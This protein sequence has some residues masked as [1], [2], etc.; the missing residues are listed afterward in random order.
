[1][2]KKIILFLLLF[3][4]IVSAQSVLKNGSAYKV[5]MSEQ[6]LALI[7]QMLSE[8][9]SKKEIPGAVALVARKGQIVF[10][11]SYGEAS[12]GKAMD[13][14][15]I[16]RIASQT[17]A[18]TSTAVIMLWEEG[19]FRLDDPISKYIP[20]FAKMEVLD[21]FD[22]MDSS[23]TTKPA[24]TEITIRHLLTHTSG[25]GYGMIDNDDFKKIFQKAGITDA[26][27]TKPIILKEN[28]K[29]LA[30]MPLHFNPGEQYHYSESIDVL[31][32]FVEV[33]SGLPL[34]IFFQERI[35]KPLGMNDTHFYLPEFKRNRLASVITKE[36]KDWKV[37]SDSTYFNPNY[38]I[39]GAKTFFSG[40]AG[41]SS[42]AED[43]AKFL[44]MYL[45]GGFYNGHR[46]LS[47]T[48]V[49]TIMQNQIG[50]FW[51]GGSHTL[52]LAFSLVTEK[53]VAT[54]GYGSEGTFGW[55]GYF[56]T[57]FFADPKEQVIGVLLKQTANIGADN[58]GWKFRQLT[59]SAIN[60]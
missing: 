9:V 53:G 36:N 46:L 16:F 14:N 24:S 8:A 35:F 23:Y 5:G 50:D 51:K 31:G 45:N 34:D 7:D 1:M 21:T 12:P 18:I 29:K 17:K 52:G 57:E 4:F 44:Q 2:Y 19:K 48:T 13:E 54:G 55:G 22:A 60:D 15:R 10:L 47:R 40:G 28:I 30:K 33:V 25:L 56:N 11:K 59:F 20:E 37:F 42:T 3:P 39:E 58:T 27:T 43:Y 41:L 6:R 26:F 38:P 32:H 49:N